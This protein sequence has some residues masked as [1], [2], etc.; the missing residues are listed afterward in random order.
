MGEVYKATDTNLK[1]QVAIKV[2]PASVVG[3][4]DRL[5]RFQREAEVLA[6]LNHPNIAQIYGLEKSDG[7]IAL[8]MELVE[9][10]TLADRIA[11]GAIPIDEA[12]PIAKQIAEALEA[13]HEQGIIHRDLKPANIKVRSDGTVKVLDFGLAK[14]LEP[15]G[16]MAVSGSEAQTITTPAMTQAGMILGTAAYMSPEQAR[17]KKVDKRADIWAFGCVLFEILSAK[18]AFGGDD[19]V[20]VLGAVTRL[21]PDW[22]ALPPAT[23]PVI[24]TLVRG[25]LQKDQRRRVGDVSTAIFLIEGLREV[26]VDD[27]SRL[28]AD[29]P[30]W[31]RAIP[32]VLA[33][34]IAAA[35]A[36]ALVWAIKPSAPMLVTRSRWILPA[37]QQFTTDSQLVGI[38]PD[39]TQMVYVANQRLFLR[40][41]SELD[42]RPVEGSDSPGITLDAVSS[43]VFSPDGRSIAYWDQGAIKRIP[44][45]GGTAVPLCQSTRLWGMSW[46]GDEIVYGEGPLGIMR[47]SANGGMPERI[48]SVESTELAVSPQMLPGNRAVLFTTLA[49]GADGAVEQWDTARIVVHAMGSGERKVVVERG[50]HARYLSSGHLVYVLDGVL[51]AAPFDERRLQVIGRAVA[52]VNGIRRGAFGNTSAKYSVS[53]SG[54]L[55]FVPGPASMSA[56]LREVVRMNRKG[57]VEQLPLPPN[58]YS[59]LRVS[60]DGTQLAFGTDN[61]KEANVSVYDL[62]RT[63]VPRRLTFGGGNRFPI[64]SGDGQQVVFQSRSRRRSRPLLAASRRRRHGAAPHDTRQG[65]RSHSGIVVREGR[66]LLV[67]CGGG[68]ECV[69][70][71]VLDGG[72]EGGTVWRPAVNGPVQ[73]RVLARWA[74]AS[75]HTADRQS[76]QRVRRAVPS[77]RRQVS[78]H[79]RKRTSSRLAVRRQG[80]LVPS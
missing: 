32:A 5:T 65:H 38:S 28:S 41:L 59:S 17:G 23:P 61:G 15:A 68:P 14:A 49:A 66:R 51:F 2:L 76:G 37:A 10:P 18:R 26:D 73:F 9:G 21:E 3:D 31:R 25:C 75:L 77:H 69:A 6:A 50:S 53:A 64:W 8:V 70:V 45:G 74:M 24:R 42:A 35:S 62:S 20:D 55:V 22:T 56:A 57:G 1:R 34:C 36:G 60:P 4:V 43:P 52:V 30:L 78:D 12:L 16:A 54:S 80:A 67:Q 71:D 13:A 44:I 63:N 72:K 27:A 29:R 48:A 79:H 47:V 40:S 33:A 58:V 46:S 39:G 19:V 7:T 11:Q